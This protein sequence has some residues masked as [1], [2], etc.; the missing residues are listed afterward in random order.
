MYIYICV[1]NNACIFYLSLSSTYKTHHMS[2][3]FL[4]LGMSFNMFSSSIHLPMNDKISF[5]LVA[6]QYFTVY[7]QHTFLVHSSVLAH[8]GCFHSLDIENYAAINMGCES[9][10]YPDLHSFQYMTRKGMAGPYGSS[11]FSFLRN[12]HTAFHSSCS[13]LHSHYSVQRFLFLWI[14]TN[15]CCC[16]CYWW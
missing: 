10:L 2:F 15:I 1:D 16:F 5:F 11:I 8:L 4:N 6:E 9:L 12:L 3:V 13:K 7:T 14:L